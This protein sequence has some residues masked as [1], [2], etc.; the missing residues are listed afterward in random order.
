MKYTEIFRLKEMLEKENIPFEFIDRT[1]N[2]PE[3]NFYWEHY[4]ICYPQFTSNG[5]ESDFVCS[6]VQ[7]KYTFGNEQDLLE[8]M[9]LLIDREAEDDSVLGWLTAEEVFKR[10]KK[11]YKNRLE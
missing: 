5:E 6:C 11:H 4:Q 3:A 7:G 9:G 8:I 1:I 2:Y 10:I